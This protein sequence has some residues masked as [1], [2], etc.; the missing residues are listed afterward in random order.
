MAQ[1]RILIGMPAFRGV[2]HI[3]EALQSISNQDHR[4]FCVLISVDDS[5]FETAAACEPF[6]KDSRFSLVV[7]N[8]R[9]G[10]AGNINWLM[11]QPDFDFFCYWQ[12]DDFT[13]ANYIST[14]A[15]LEHGRME[16]SARLW[17]AHRR[18]EQSFGLSAPSRAASHLGHK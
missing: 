17:D 10:W 5:D 8:H 1:P 3:H 18:N 14:H 2:D 13:S 12:H 6:L 16:R 11:S 15:H 4:D 7:Q 9:L